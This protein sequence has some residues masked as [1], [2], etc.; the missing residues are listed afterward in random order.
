[1]KKALLIAILCFPLVSGAAGRLAKKKTTTTTTTHTTME[2][3]RETNEVTASGTTMNFN[4]REQMRHEV[5]LSSSTHLP[6]GSSSALALNSGTVFWLSGGY[7]YDVPGMSALQVGGSAYI[8]TGSGSTIFQITAGPTLNFPF[9]WDLRNAFFVDGYAGITTT[10]GGT[11]A[12]STSSTAFTFGFDV[13]K[14]FKLFENLTY[15]PSFGIV[16]ATGNVVFN[17]SFMSF[18][19]VF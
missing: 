4:A 5:I 7:N 3:A 6:L 10:S 19:A 9:D 13:G 12:F 17:F 15:R 2:P 16:K 14:R 18:S 11:G 1:M 8:T